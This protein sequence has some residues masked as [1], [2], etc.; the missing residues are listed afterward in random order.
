MNCY[1]PFHL[2]HSA[3][4]IL[5][6]AWL[7][8]ASAAVAADYDLWV[9][10]ERFTS[11]HKTINCGPGTAVYNG[12]DTLTLNGV[13]IDKGCDIDGPGAGAGIV[14]R[15]SS[16]KIVLKTTGGR[17]NIITNVWGAGITT[18]NALGANGTAAARNLTFQ[19]TGVLRIFTTNAA[20]GYGV[21]VTGTSRSTALNNIFQINSAR[22][23]YT[24]LGGI[25]IASDNASYRPRI[26]ITTKEGPGVCTTN[27]FI[28]QSR[29]T[30]TPT[31]YLTIDAA[32]DGL[33][34]H[35][36]THTYYPQLTIKAGGVGIRCDG[37]L[38]DNALTPLTIDSQGDCFAI[39]GTL[40]LNNERKFTFASGGQALPSPVTFAESSVGSTI[41]IK[42]LGAGSTG[43]SVPSGT[44]KVRLSDIEIESAGDGLALGTPASG[45]NAATPA[46]LTVHSG[47]LKITAAGN[48]ISGVAG[49]T[50]LFH[51]G[52][53]RLA[54][55]NG[56][57][58][59]ALA[60]GLSAITVRG[61]AAVRKGALD[62]AS[63]EIRRSATYTWA[64]ASA[65]ADWS[66]ASTWAGG[67][68]PAAADIVRFEDSVELP[69]GVV[70]ADFAG[71]FNVA[72]G[73]TLSVIFPDPTATQ[74]VATAVEAG[75]TFVKKGAGAVSIAPWAGTYPGAIRVEAGTVLFRG[76][77][78]ENAPG[79]FG[80]LMVLAGARAVITDSPFANRHG[81]MTLCS[82]A[83]VQMTV[84]TA[85]LSTSARI[86]AMWDAWY[87]DPAVTTARRKF[88]T[89]PFVLSSAS[90]YTSAY[91][92]GSSFLT[93]GNTENWGRAVWLCSFGEPRSMTASYDDAS[94]GRFFVDDANF[95]ADATRTVPRG[96]HVLDWRLN[97]NGGGVTI[98]R[99]FGPSR[100]NPGD[101][102][103]ADFLWNGVCFGGLTLAA[104]A[105]LDI[106]AGQAVAFASDAP[107]N[108]AGAV[109]GAADSCLTVALSATPFPLD[110]LGAYPGR[111][112]IG[113]PAKAKA[114][115]NLSDA[116]FTVIGHGELIATNG[117]EG[118]IGGD[119][120]G[121]LNI[122][123]G[124]ALQPAAAL[125][126][127]AT[128]TGSGTFIA[129]PG[130]P[131][132]PG[133][134]G[135]VVLAGTSA[136]LTPGPASQWEG[137][138]LADGASFEIPSS[139]AARSSTRVVLEDWTT[140]AW[141]L[142]GAT[143]D[144]GYSAGAA[145]VDNAGALVLTD[146]GGRQRRTAFI[147]N[148]VFCL[149][150][151]WQMSFTYSASPLGKYES[152][153]PGEGLAIILQSGGP[154][155]CD[156]DN[157]AA[158]AMRGV[159]SS[160]LY[161]SYGIAFRQNADGGVG[162][163]TVS[164][165]AVGGDQIDSASVSGIDLSRPVRVTVSYGGT[166]MT[167]RFEQDGVRRER[168]IDYANIGQAYGRFW[169]GF[170]AGT[171][172]TKADGTVV[173]LV[174][175]ITDFSGWVLR[176]TGLS[177]P[178]DGYG[179]DND[180][181]HFNGTVTREN[182]TI[183][184]H[185]DTRTF[186]SAINPNAL[187]TKQGYR[188][189]WREIVSAR[190]T[191]GDPRVSMYGSVLLQGYGTGYYNAAQGY[192]LPAKSPAAFGLLTATDNYDAKW[193]W[194]WVQGN[195]V[196]LL[197]A[198]NCSLDNYVAFTNDVTLYF[199]GKATAIADIWR[200]ANMGTTTRALTCMG[201]FETLGGKAYLS[202]V[203]SYNSNSSATRW[204]PISFSDIEVRE[205]RDVDMP[206][207]LPLAVADHASA[208]ISFGGVSTN[209][210]A[211]AATV[212]TLALGGG[213]T[214]SLATASGKP[215]IAGLGTIVLGGSGET[216]AASE[217]VTTAFD[218]IDLT[219]AP[220]PGPGAA[221]LVVTGSWT[222][223]G[224]IL[225]IRI[226]AQ[227]VGRGA[228][229]V[230]DLSGASLVGALPQFRVVL[231]ASDGSERESPVAS[232]RLTEGGKLRICTEIRTMILLR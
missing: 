7:L 201:D 220:Y 28:L 213:S 24:A 55:M 224:G 93:T 211:P 104:G 5:P 231:V 200:K 226:P 6:S 98:Y 69:A 154:R 222:T 199:D 1:K 150:D 86:R 232:A 65:D 54:S 181:W 21:Y 174:Q 166:R 73:K 58:A 34:C 139:L 82:A 57:S 148:T 52:D 12:S 35:A 131:V 195:T 77:G 134:A 23:G 90:A 62:G 113:Y 14:S 186:G 26:S 103:T 168:T 205:L 126:A 171:G 53:T 89:P 110:A 194:G 169:F 132:P 182:G 193:P 4:R 83:N 196:T 75:A 31:P 160:A 191:T 176:E 40:T 41:R 109:T 143:K 59:F 187:S 145:Y 32:G 192:G 13:I 16:L 60:D 39:G 135:Q 78:Y 188:V 71:V 46:A 167:F 80:D 47:R 204:R 151:I 207:S 95:T 72:A 99:Y 221:P 43:L 85:S 42:C 67:E 214:L 19:D 159:S 114:F 141:S 11:S 125:N 184:F 84:P 153:R 68:V 158:Y 20:T 111:V 61:R 9:N 50:V 172:A 127:G 146:D 190:V 44:L 228:F 140:G 3:F 210:T 209:A 88:F 198:L 96:W 64:G 116:A 45:G 218:T 179:A 101:V 38:T 133:F 8:A 107:F 202:L 118:R 76:N 206:V 144:A 149:S 25:T 63:V 136:S 106:G 29:I 87:G 2:L 175:K 100:I 177:A 208:T 70:P 33:V 138:T 142:N 105:T 122:P 30:T 18:E 119:F 36:F 178:L 22:A 230:A 185:K 91:L 27:D 15:L 216:I 170:A 117:V 124:V 128:V 51:G 229:D 164:L 48:A 74:T 130:V 49:S 219:T 155:A 227:W 189:K 79:F 161:S 129:S 197:G 225:T 66:A 223:R 102:I 147:T 120:A 180:A 92:A 157:S 123:A 121:K 17:E 97:N 183:T 156:T 203:G 115:S 37:A 173:G 165:G 217:G 163:D 162:I 56:A 215:V 152:E 81:A 10:N 137:V 94:T 212:E 112:E 108:V